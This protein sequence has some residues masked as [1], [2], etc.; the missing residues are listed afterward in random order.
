MRA[1]RL[2]PPADCREEIARRLQLIADHHHLNAIIGVNA[3]AVAEAERCQRL[4]REGGLVGPLHGVP[5]IVKDNIACASLPITLGCR[6]L[7]SLR[8]TSDARVIRRLKAA[9]AIILARANMSEFAFDVRSRSSLGGDVRNPQRP[10][11]TAGGSS[12]GSAAAVAVGMADG[13]LG[14]D[15]GG[16]IRI[17]CS[18]NGLVGLRPAFRRQMLEGV[19][20]LSVSKDTVGPMVH[21]VRDAAL[22]HAI[23]HGKRPV[24][25]PAA[26]LKSLRLGVISALEG[27]DPAQ[28]KVWHHALEALRLAGA[29][30]V[31]VDLPVLTE[32][33]SR[34]CLSLCEFQV[35]INGWLAH[36]PGAPASLR[37]IIDSGEYLPEFRPLLEQ[38]LRSNGLKTP[39]WLSGRR[40]QRRLY[41]T[42]GQAAEQDAIDAFV[43]PTVSRQ[44]ISLEKMPPGCAPELAA[45]SGLPAITLPCGLVQNGLPVGMELLAKTRDERALLSIA[46][47]CESVFQPG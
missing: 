46:L 28:L 11:V 20:P 1:M 36:Q 8:A 34:P 15:T 17:P 40:F 47:A 27:A 31:E 23:M 44:P 22:L 30:L 32:V 14:T 41:Q 16:S 9:G 2:I 33:Q 18:Y 7:A 39:Q 13:A 10:T 38:M 37:A 5:L 3:D 25:P 42:L 45:I 12:G 35:A 24:A 43:Y 26:S 21:G 6:G 4:R 19:A 29:T